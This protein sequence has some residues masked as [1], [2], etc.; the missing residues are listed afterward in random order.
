M[1]LEWPE[2]GN[3]ANKVARQPARLTQRTVCAVTRG[4]T[5]Q[6]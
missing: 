5:Q 3:T 6:G 2:L 4:Q 1:R